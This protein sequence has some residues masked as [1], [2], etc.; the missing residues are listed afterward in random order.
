M[1]EGRE[2]SHGSSGEASERPPSEARAVALVARAVLTHTCSQQ[3]ATPTGRRECGRDRP[4]ALS[5]PTRHGNRSR[6]ALL[7]QT[8]RP[9]T[10][11]RRLEPRT[12]QS[13]R[14]QRVCCC[15]T[16][17]ASA[18]HLRLMRPKPLGW[19][20][21][22]TAAST[23][24]FELARAPHSLTQTSHPRGRQYRL[25]HSGQIAR[26]GRGV[27]TPIPFGDRTVGR[28]PAIA[29][30]QS[31]QLAKPADGSVMRWL[32]G[33]TKAPELLIIGNTSLTPKC[34][35]SGACDGRPQRQAWSRAVTKGRLASRNARPNEYWTNSAH[36]SAHKRR[37]ETMFHVK[38]DVDTSG[39]D[40][41][42]NS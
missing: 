21:L 42:S 37:L 7:T 8:H 9:E 39:P 18:L 10:S 19:P 33:S 20:V 34:G 12:C 5:S 23:C 17:R 25:K 28:G 30:A 40:G 24:P 1:I 13:L 6:H 16:P 27:Y 3:R 35:R 11:I 41:M 26:V 14:R 38:R 36:N 22:L 29:T 4:T 31:S 15:S 2:A 32:R